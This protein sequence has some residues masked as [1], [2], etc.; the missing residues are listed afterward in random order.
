MSFTSIGSR[1]EGLLNMGEIVDFGASLSYGRM[2]HLPTDHIEAGTSRFGFRDEC[3]QTLAVPV[4]LGALA[5]LELC[6]PT[7]GFPSGASI[8]IVRSPTLARSQD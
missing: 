3:T 8:L 6:A 1:G 5:S 2:N 7:L 4:C